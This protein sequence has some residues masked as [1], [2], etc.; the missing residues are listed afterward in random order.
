ME[1][2]EL[3]VLLVL[4]AFFLYGV[5]NIIAAPILL[6]K[7]YRKVGFKKIGRSSL[8]NPSSSYLLESLASKQ[9]YNGLYRGYK[10]SH[11]KC[12]LQ[13]RKALTFSKV[14]RKQLQSRWSVTL[15]CSKH[16]LPEFSLLPKTEPATVLLMLS[17]SSVD[18]SFDEE[19]DRRYLLRTEHAE[20]VISLITTDLR[21][22]L[23]DRELAA[24]EVVDNRVIIKRA[25]PTERLKT[26]LLDEFN[27]A[28]IIAEQELFSD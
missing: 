15:V 7:F 25:W 14:K 8:D 6:R 10:I 16:R 27:A 21:S 3:V 20:P 4:A 11:A 22:F 26:N 1:N 19:L 12:F 17:E 5:A 13:R 18:L 24:I 9:L 2:G 28:I 23:L